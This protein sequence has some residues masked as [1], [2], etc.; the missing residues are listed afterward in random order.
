MDT[1]RMYAYIAFAVA[2]AAL[3]NMIVSFIEARTRRS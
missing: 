1:A 2:I 3:L